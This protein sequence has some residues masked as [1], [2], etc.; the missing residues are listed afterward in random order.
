M[1]WSFGDP[2]GWMVGGLF[3]G[4]FSLVLAGLSMKYPFAWRAWGRS[5][6]HDRRAAVSAL[7]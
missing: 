6:S 3:F 1:S 2:T 7:S 5:M 4:F